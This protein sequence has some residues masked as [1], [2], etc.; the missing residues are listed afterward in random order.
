MEMELNYKKSKLRKAKNI[1]IPDIFNR[2]LK[3][4]IKKIDTLFDEGI[5]PGSA[6]TLTARAGCG[7][8]TFMLQVLNGL[9]KNGYNTGY[10]SG[11][12]SIYQ[13]AYTANRVRAKEVPVANIT[14]ID[15]IKKLM[16]ELDV[17][18]VDSFQALTTKTKMN[19]R[20]KEMY[21]VQELTR[22]AKETECTIVFVMHLTKSGDLKGGTVVPHT[23]DANMKISRLPD[24][25]DDGARVIYFE[26]NRFGPLNELE[27]LIE[28]NGYDFNATVIKDEAPEAKNKASSKKVR[29][30]EDI[31]KIMSLVARPGRTN[32]GSVAKTLDDNVS[33]AR[34]LLK[35]L[36]TVGK[37]KKVGRGVKA[38][39][40]TNKGK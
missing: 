32:L 4:G 23:V 33:R 10:L 20:Q 1:K 5:L 6:V 27:C 16:S 12:E 18:V 36:E 7:K 40:K 25:D 35:D 19:S 29:R 30:E 8:T 15:E 26:K 13:L 9:T 17:V 21:A 31:R 3:T 38:Y 24:A 34:V 28:R 37:I 22:T 14:D 2:R 39:W 11:E